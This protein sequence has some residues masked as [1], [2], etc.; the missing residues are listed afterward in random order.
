[1]VR[2]MVAFSVVVVVF[3][4]L[5]ALEKIRHDRALRKISIRILV[6]GTRGKTSVTRMLS[7]ALRSAGVRTYAK[8]T[9]SVARWILP[10]GSEVD[11]RGKRLPS[12]KEHIPFVR[13]AARKGA[14]AIVV[15]CMALLPENQWLI[16]NQLVRQH[17]T[18]ITNAGIDH[19]EEIGRDADET[20]Q[21]LAQSIHPDG[22][23]ITGEPGFS[24]FAR[25]TANPA[26]DFPEEILSRFRFPAF[27][28]NVA[29]VLS[30]CDTLGL[31]REK[32]YQGMLDAKPDIGM[33]GVFEWKSYTITNGF[34]A[35]DPESFARLLEAMIPAPY[36]MIFNHR[37]DRPQRLRLM[38]DE[39]GKAARKPDLVGVIG[40]YKKQAAV[41]LQRRIGVPSFALDNPA[42]W[43][44]ELR[45]FRIHAV[46]CAGNIKGGG[47]NFL[48]F[49]LENGTLHA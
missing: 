9:G 47:Q 43:L 2:L 29:L 19:I 24:G 23:V 26:W 4:V 12:V 49:L 17:I 10:D 13:A 36:V 45:P 16:G 8:T 48:E 5:M 28:G 32:V 44:E 25:K 21:T 46:L 39:L 18:V 14:E 6:N 31:P 15:E 3:A 22:I 40:S 30:T 34:S 33:L 11:C 35:N 42:D 41:Y 1:M 7:A 27:A 37:G 38:A 20:I